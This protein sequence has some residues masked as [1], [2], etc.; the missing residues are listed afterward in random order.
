MD[1]NE[2]EDGAHRLLLPRTRPP[3]L[4]TTTSLLAA[5]VVVVLLIGGGLQ[6]RRQRTPK[7]QPPQ[8]PVVVLCK[9]V[10][11]CLCW[12]GSN[13]RL[14]SKL[15]QFYF[16]E[17]ETATA[18]ITVS[19][20]FIHPVKSLR[21][22]AVPTSTLNCQG[23]TQDRRCMIVYAVPAS[24]ASSSSSSSSRQSSHRFLTQRQCPS[25]AT[26]AATI[27]LRRPASMINGEQKELVLEHTTV[28]SKKSKKETTIQGKTNKTP[29]NSNNNTQTVCIP[30]ESDAAGAPPSTYYAGIWD[31][32]VLVRD[33]GDAAAQFLQ[34]IVDRDEELILAASSSTSI[35]SKDETALVGNQRRRVRLVT[36]ATTAGATTAASCYDFDDRSYIPG[37]A[38]TW[39]GGYLGKPTL[40]DGVR[41]VSVLFLLSM[42]LYITFCCCRVSQSSL[43]L[44]I[45]ILPFCCFSI[46]NPIL[47]FV[48]IA[49]QLRSFRS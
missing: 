45:L 48:P 2:N 21:A 13:L 1:K 33:L 34:R 40:T 19:G 4:V 6:Q 22:I 12:L 8:H 37:Y 7:Q 44:S 26:I 10:I 17:E 46:L 36:L 29:N 23:L 42:L 35:T 31:D 41:A 39:T 11:S 15:V 16:K 49:I 47:Q 20:L 9:V 5:V 32:T 24:S 27:R 28:V 38:K 30:L 25:L 3:R 14:R 43:L 18:T